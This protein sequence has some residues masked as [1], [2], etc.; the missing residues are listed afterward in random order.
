[1]VCKRYFKEYLE[2]LSHYL[3]LVDLAISALP[4]VSKALKLI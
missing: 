2:Q 3:T 1:M 4:A